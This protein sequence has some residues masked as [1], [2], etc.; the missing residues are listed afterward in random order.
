MQ[1]LKNMTCEGLRTEALER[2]MLRDLLNQMYIPDPF[3]DGW[4]PEKHQK[5]KDM[6]DR[7]YVRLSGDKVERRKILDK[8]ADV[9]LKIEK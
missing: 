8:A 4:T 9:F 5:G 6:A 1:E 7:E 3:E 2:W